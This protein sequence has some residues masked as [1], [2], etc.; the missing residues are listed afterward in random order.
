MAGDARRRVRGTFA[1]WSQGVCGGDDQHEEVPGGD[2]VGGSD[3]HGVRVGG[4]AVYGS[5]WRLASW[6][7]KTASRERCDRPVLERCGRASL[8]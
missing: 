8:G 5:M 3:S 6:P 7:L 2:G 1:T 4:R